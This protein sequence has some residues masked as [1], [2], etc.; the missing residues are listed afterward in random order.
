[1]P[2][3]STLV[4]NDVYGING[5]AIVGS[6]FSIVA[7][8]MANLTV[9]TSGNAETGAKSGAVRLYVKIVQNAKLLARGA[10]GA[11][12]KDEAP[13]SAG[14]NGADGRDDKCDGFGGYRGR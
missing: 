1:V 4:A 3:G 2:A 9:D 6:D 10:A 13:G 7:R 11:P 8:K 12:G 5:G 14:T